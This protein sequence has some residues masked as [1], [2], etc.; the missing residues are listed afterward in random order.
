[1]KVFKEM[2]NT[3]DSMDVFYCEL[4]RGIELACEKCYFF[5]IFDCFISFEFNRDYFTH[6][7]GDAPLYYE[8]DGEA[9]SC[10]EDIDKKLETLIKAKKLD[11]HYDCY[12]KLFN[13]EMEGFI[14]KI[15]S[16]NKSDVEDCLSFLAKW[17][18]VNG[19]YENENKTRWHAYE[20]DIEDI[21]DKIDEIEPI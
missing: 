6:N 1:M 5:R 20:W 14:E 9:V 18:Y 12:M 11:D 3:K 15:I 17:L 21:K 8:I 19:I 13:L 2:Y 10:D 7:Y 16:F 4:D